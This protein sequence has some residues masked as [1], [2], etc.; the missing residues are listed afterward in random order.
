[1]S[2]SG[3]GSGAVELTIEGP[4][5]IV[6]DT[7]GSV[8][9]TDGLTH[10][11]VTFSVPS[12]AGATYKWNVKGAGYDSYQ[13]HTISI[14]PWAFTSIHL[15]CTCTDP[16]GTIRTALKDVRVKFEGTQLDTVVAANRQVDGVVGTMGHPYDDPTSTEVYPAGFQE[17]PS[18]LLTVGDMVYFIESYVVRS[19]NLITKEFKSYCGKTGNNGATDGVGTAARIQYNDHLVHDGSG[20]IYDFG[21]SSCLI[22]KIDLAAGSITTVMGVQNATEQV[23][24]TAGK[25]TVLEAV[26][27]A[28]P[29]GKIYILDRRPSSSTV[30]LRY[31]DTQ[32]AGGPCLTTVG[33]VP[34]LTSANSNY[35]FYNG[36]ILFSD[37]QKI[38]MVNVQTLELTYED[39]TETGNTATPMDFSPTCNHP[40]Y[41][42]P[43]GFTLLGDDLYFEDPSGTL[44]CRH[45]GTPFA[46]S[47]SVQTLDAFDSSFLYIPRTASTGFI[48]YNRALYSVNF[49]GLA[50]APYLE[51]IDESRFGF[52]DSMVFS[53][54]S[55]Q[56]NLGGDLYPACFIPLTHVA[57]GDT[58]VLNVLTDK[59]FQLAGV[60]EAN[61]LNFSRVY[62]TITHMGETSYVVHYVAMVQNTGAD[63]PP[64]IIIYPRITGP[65]IAHSVYLRSTEGASLC[66]STAKETKVTFDSSNRVASISTFSP[67]NTAIFK[68]FDYTP[69]GN[70]KTIKTWFCIRKYD[71]EDRAFLGVGRVEAFTYDSASGNLLESKIWDSYEYEEELKRAQKE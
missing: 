63:W 64:Y 6:F 51:D 35:V 28:G 20:G 54:T 5:E 9:N 67:R 2:Q 65:R 61:E 19:F 15:K 3:G 56:I 16:D 55:P 46:A 31:L 43:G 38:G 69:S 40:T 50:K 36:Y 45:L 47:G 30:V 23:D 60:F 32:A 13:E 12:L 8:N 71:I 1:V 41:V 24:G 42:Y 39:G 57:V 21:I 11:A 58:V 14:D 66:L 33:V 62:S 22:R 52:M 49:K 68:E 37:D 7:P 59:P 48:F 17:T 18:Q 4:S 27:N 26:C 10:P 70:I 53:R 25:V 34:N 44:R 29:D